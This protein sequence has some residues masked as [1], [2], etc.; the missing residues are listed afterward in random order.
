MSPSSP[1][2]K[3]GDLVGLKP[4]LPQPPQEAILNK[5]DT[6]WEQLFSH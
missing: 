1:F 6:I 2:A 4:D 3:R 5:V